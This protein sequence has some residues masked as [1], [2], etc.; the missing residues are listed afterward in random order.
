MAR[1]WGHSSAKLSLLSGMDLLFI[2]HDFV[3]GSALARVSS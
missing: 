1:T 2:I 3:F